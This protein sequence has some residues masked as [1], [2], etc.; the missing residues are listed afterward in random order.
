MEHLRTTDPVEWINLLKMVCEPNIVATIPDPKN[1]LFTPKEIRHEVNEKSLLRHL[2]LTLRKRYPK[3]PVPFIYGVSNSGKTTL[4]S[5]IPELYP[6]EA[7]GFLNSSTASLSGIHKDIAVLYCDEFK[8]ELISR[9]DLL[10]LLDGA[11]PLT[12]RKLHHDAVLI[13]NPLMPILLCAN[14]RP[15]YYN[16]DSAALDNRLVYFYL[17]NTILPDRKKGETIRSQHLFTV[18]YLNDWLEKNPE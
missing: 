9:E 1:R 15:A 7:Q 6:I 18:R 13:K 5:F 10:I 8:T 16:D 3:Q 4:T 17:T 2:A 11:Q 14:F 12:V